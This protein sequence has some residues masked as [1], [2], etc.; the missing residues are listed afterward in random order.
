MCSIR[1]RQARLDAKGLPGKLEIPVIQKLLGHGD[2][3][4]AFNKQRRELRNREGW[5]EA[6]PANTFLQY[7]VGSVSRL[8]PGHNVAAGSNDYPNLSSLI[9]RALPTGDFRN[10]R[11]CRVKA[12]KDDV[13]LLSGNPPILNRVLCRSQQSL[14]LD[15]EEA[16]RCDDVCSLGDGLFSLLTFCTDVLS[17]HHPDRSDDG[18]NR[19]RRLQPSRSFCRFDTFFANSKNEPGDEKDRGGDQCVE[20]SP[21]FSIKFIHGAILA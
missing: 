4:S 11:Q 20:D 21:L 5:Q 9:K 7:P 10:S 13:G 19:G 14:H 1:S 17:I 18:P 15:G 12:R 6:L 8:D 16:D 2:R 3:S